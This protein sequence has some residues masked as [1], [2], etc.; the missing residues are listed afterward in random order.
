MKIN[1]L[2][3]ISLLFLFSCQQQNV[4]KVS[5]TNENNKLKVGV[6]KGNGAG[7]VSVIE[8]IEALKIDTG[9]WA[10]PISAAEIQNGDLANF[11]AIIIPGGS[12]SK[13]LNNL[14]E[15][16][17][18]KLRD[19]AKVQGKGIVGICAGAYFLSSTKGY[20]NLHIASSV[21]LDRPHYNRGR[22]LVQFTTTAKGND[23]FPELAGKN[24]F[25][26]YY[27]GPLLA[28]SDSTPGDYTELGTFVSDIH[29]DNFAPQGLTPGK[30]FL[31]NEEVGN[32]RVFLC[33]GHPESTPGMRWMI[34]RMIRWVCN[35][36][37]VSYN[38]KWIRPE[39]NDK[40]IIFDRALKKYEKNLFWKLFS[41]D[42]NEQIAAM[43]SLYALRSR[44]AVRWSIGLLRSNKAEVRKHAADLLKE[45]EYSDALPD[46]WAAYN[47]EQN[48]DTKASIKSAI[49]FL[50]NK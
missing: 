1:L 14:G 6:F 7:A 48:A 2:L 36:E 39:I 40:E 13:Q 42:A 21:H 34:P 28:H 35:S 17:A 19:F 31:L 49:D 37:L 44:P 8:T 12:G 9:I 32:G 43:D 30:T 25:L 10:V 22:G 27:D 23:Y 45:T 33:A 41:D 38:P 5:Q 18:D 20:P 16:G 24:S 50:E 4:E 29:P 3:L 11:D 46:L 26:Q 15:S 47:A